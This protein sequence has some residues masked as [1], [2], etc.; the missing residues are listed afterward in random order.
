[1]LGKAWEGRGGI[2]SSAAIAIRA[3]GDLSFVTTDCSPSPIADRTLRVAESYQREVSGDARL[4]MSKWLSKVIQRTLHVRRV[5]KILFTFE[6]LE[7][8]LSR[9]VK[10]FQKPFQGP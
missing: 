10:S 9:L 4:N 6:G 1:M 3:I 7:K 8:I 5:P 2:V